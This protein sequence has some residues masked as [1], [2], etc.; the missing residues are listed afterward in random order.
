MLHR[1]LAEKDLE[2]VGSLTIRHILRFEHWVYNYLKHIFDH[3]RD[4]S[5]HILVRHSQEWIMVDLNEPNTE[6]FIEQEIKAKE[7]KAVFTLIGIHS[8]LDTEEGIDYDV[9]DARQE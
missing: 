2:V 6:I 3:S 9:F 4:E 7:L 1:S 5:P 8:P